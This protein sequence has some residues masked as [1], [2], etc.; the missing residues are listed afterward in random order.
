[1]P[2]RQLDA[3]VDPPEVRE[4]L[5]CGSRLGQRA[6]P[7]ELIVV[8]GDEAIGVQGHVCDEQGE[9]PGA[10]KRG[11]GSFQVAGARSALMAPAG[12]RDQL[13]EVV[14]ICRRGR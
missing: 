3:L 5:R 13:S 8:V 6:V 11:D 2:Q 4:R 9:P 14:S 12:D 10:R 1:M 7:P